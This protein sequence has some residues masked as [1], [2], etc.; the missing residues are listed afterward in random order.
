MERGFHSQDAQRSSGPLELALA[1]Q[2]EGGSGGLLLIEG[3][4]PS[5]TGK[6]HGRK[7]SGL[8]FYD[9]GQRLIG[10]LELD[11]LLL[12]LF[13]EESKVLHHSVAIRVFETEQWRVEHGVRLSN[14][15]QPD[16]LLQSFFNHRKMGLRD[17]VLL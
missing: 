14:Q 6:V 16:P 11:G 2:G 3:H 12:T 17:L 13:V 4:L 5:Q 8:F 9:V 15:S 1:R 7:E 10:F